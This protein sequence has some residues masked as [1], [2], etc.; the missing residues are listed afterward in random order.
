MG[1]D[2]APNAAVAGSGMNK[3]SMVL[4]GQVELTP[5]TGKFALFGGLFAHYDFYLYG[6]AGYVSLVKAGSTMAP[7]CKDKSTDTTTCS[8]TGSSLGP[9]FGGGLHSYFNDWFG[10]DLDLRDVVIKDNPAG[11][12]VNGDQFADKR[13]L[14]WSSHWMVTLG[15]T[16]FFPKADISP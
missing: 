14:T 11:R 7:A 12:D 8:T 2:R 4:A 15:V 10:L 13:D 3:P 16:V 6:G 9:T 1:E 5:F